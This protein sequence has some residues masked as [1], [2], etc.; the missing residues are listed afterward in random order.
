MHCGFLQICQMATQTQDSSS[1]SSLTEHYHICHRHQPTFFKST[2]MLKAH[3]SHAIPFTCTINQASGTITA[4]SFQER[5]VDR[6]FHQ[7]AQNYDLDRD[8]VW[9]SYP[10][11]PQTHKQQACKTSTGPSHLWLKQAKI[12][13]TFTSV[14]SWLKQVMVHWTFTFIASWLKQAM[15]HWTI[16]SVARPAVTQTRFKVALESNK[17]KDVTVFPRGVMYLIVT[18]S[19]TMP[20]GWIIDIMTWNDIHTS[21]WDWW[22]HEEEKAI[23]TRDY[24]FLVMYCLSDKWLKVF[25]QCVK[26]KN[27][28]HKSMVTVWCGLD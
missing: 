6:L 20:I 26:N 25:S 12:H 14:A 2:H 4:N 21:G 3:W 8:C 27:K 10:F 9:Q 23:P 11:P 13:W 7:T 15:I 24:V 5:L 16:T 22:L 19:N 17:I 28:S 18:F 1:I